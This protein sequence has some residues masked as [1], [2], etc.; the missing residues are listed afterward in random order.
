MYVCV[1]M[2]TGTCN[3]MGDGEFSSHDINFITTKGLENYYDGFAGRGRMG[4]V[5]MLP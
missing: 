4:N 3:F 1:L 5:S 2:H